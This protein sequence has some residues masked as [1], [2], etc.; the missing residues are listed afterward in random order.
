M[1]V[2]MLLVT[3]ITQ[4]EIIWMTINIELDRMWKKEWWPDSRKYPGV[5]QQKLGETTRSL[6]RDRVCAGRDSN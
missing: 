3:Q 1:Y 2:T 5:S 6:R 4:S